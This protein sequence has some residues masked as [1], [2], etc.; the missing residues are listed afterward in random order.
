[1]LN[2]CRLLG[3]VYAPTSACT[4]EE[5][6]N[7]GLDSAHRECGNQDIEIVMGDLNAKA[8]SEQDPLKE[9]V[10]MNGHGRRN[11]RETYGLLLLFFAMTRSVLKSFKSS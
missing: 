7:S 2:S 10:G 5:I 8:G 1:M 11:D 3:V 9:I 6:V 4:E